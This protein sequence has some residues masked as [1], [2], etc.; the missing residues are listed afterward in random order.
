MPKAL[1]PVPIEEVE[2]IT[3]IRKRFV[4]PGMSLGALSPEA[5]ETLSIALN[6]IKSGAI[7]ISASGMCDA[8]RIKHH[9]RHNLA[10]AESSI[11]IAGFQAA[12]TL[13]RR[14][15]D[16]VGWFPL[17]A[18]ILLDYLLNLPALPRSASAMPTI[19]WSDARL[20]PDHV[21]WAG[22]HERDRVTREQGLHGLAP[23]N[24]GESAVFSSGGSMKNMQEATERICEL[25]GN[26]VGKVSE[27]PV[28][29]VNAPMLAKER[30][31]CPDAADFGV[32]ER[33]VELL[34]DTETPS[35][36]LEIIAGQTA[37]IR[38]RQ[39]LRERQ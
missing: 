23:T 34:R 31:P 26:L 32:M 12:G 11:V 36:A 39:S 18:T 2:S 28:S 25:K 1:K 24:R 6:R 16:R 37:N 15:V 17:L 38:R 22:T 10:R 9:L 35:A 29:Y 21:L 8:G 30:G 3:S 33:L 14:L 5:H 4:T 20:W 27:E 13:G 19:T 7:I